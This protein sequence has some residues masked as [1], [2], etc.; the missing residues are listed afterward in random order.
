MRQRLLVSSAHLSLPLPA[1]PCFFPNIPPTP[2]AAPAA[3]TLPLGPSLYPSL[4]VSLGIRRLRASLSPSA[5]RGDFGFSHGAA[6]GLQ[7]DHHHRARPSEGFFIL[8]DSESPCLLGLLFLLQKAPQAFAPAL[9][10]LLSLVH[11]ERARPLCVGKQGSLPASGPG[12]REEE[13]SG[14]RGRR[15]WIR[16][17]SQK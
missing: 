10:T 11:L 3:S 15:A 4:C 14:C 5:E 9:E 6:V 12:Q 13:A 2:P 1:H 16:N 7:L 8:G 17:P